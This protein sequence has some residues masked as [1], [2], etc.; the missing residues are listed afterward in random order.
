[1][2]GV[3]KSANLVPSYLEMTKSILKSN[4]PTFRTLYPIIIADLRHV[5]AMV[6]FKNSFIGLTRPF[7]RMLSPSFL[8]KIAGQRFILPFYHAVSDAHLPHI[9]PLYPVKSVKEFTRDLDFLFTYYEPIDLATFVESKRAGRLSQK[10][11]FLLSFDDGLRSFYDT[12]APILT[13][14]GV[15]AIC[16]LNSSFVDN[17]D[18]FFRYKT[19]LLI[20]SLLRDNQRKLA[21]EFL[22][23]LGFHGE[24]ETIL[25]KLK[26]HETPLLDGLATELELD[27]AAFLRTEKPYMTSEQIRSLQNKGF[28]FGAHSID[29]PLYSDLSAE[30][31]WHQTTA[32]MD[33]VTEAFHPRYKTFSFP[34][35][36]FGVSQTLFERLQREKKVDLTFGCA[37]LKS[38]SAPR[39][40][41][42]IAFE[43][44]RISG[45]EI[46][47]AEMLYCFGQRLIGKN[48]IKRSL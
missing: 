15:P 48:T 19:G 11:H 12:V 8:R 38:D 6:S 44:A 22:S 42:R 25:R 41:Q 21:T 33:A 10:P 7:A 30:A 18:L 28:D 24:P 37:G 23:S 16:F 32:S 43:R 31:Q 40:H 46:H 34:F 27:F 1:M 29:H 36:D 26:Y 17:K 9:D 4:L 20:D 39:H 3:G 45:R 13:E 14:K 47:N 5:L 35:T 2:E